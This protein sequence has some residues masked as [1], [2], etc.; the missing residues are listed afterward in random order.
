MGCKSFFWNNTNNRGWDE[1]AEIN[2]N[3]LSNT[4][5]NKVNYCTPT[6]KNIRHANGISLQSSTETDF[7]DNGSTGNYVLIDTPYINQQVAVNPISVE[8]S[9]GNKIVSTYTCNLNIPHLPLT[10]QQGH[11]FPRFPAG[12]LTS[13]GLSWDCGCTTH[14]DNCTITIMHGST[15]VLW[16]YQLSS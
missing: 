13:I 9:D 15:I 6:T 16:G 3:Y 7:A 10:V 8:I 12:T 2:T 1:G 4:Y 11:I 5:L 14:L